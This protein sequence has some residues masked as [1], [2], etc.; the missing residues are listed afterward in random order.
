MGYSGSHLYNFCSH[1]S[2]PLLQ[3]TINLKPSDCIGQQFPQ[4]RFLLTPRS[5]SHKICITDYITGTTVQWSHLHH[6]LDWLS[7]GSCTELATQPPPLVL[8]ARLLRCPWSKDT[9]RNLFFIFI[10]CRI[11][12]WKRLSF[13][14][15]I[16][17]HHMKTL[18][19]TDVCCCGWCCSPIS[20]SSCVLSSPLFLAQVIWKKQEMNIHTL[21]YDKDTENLH[22]Y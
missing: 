18:I 6:R 16:P 14:I 15:N 13:N 3:I 5:P 11:E 2:N 10:L 19:W 7:P 4:A 22:K 21:F 12:P 9:Q 8:H 20:A 1:A 17:K